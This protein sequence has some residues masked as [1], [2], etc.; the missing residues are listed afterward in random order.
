[1]PNTLEILAGR[2]N[3][4]V[5]EIEVRSTSTLYCSNHWFIVF[6]DQNGE[7][8]SAE[9]TKRLDGLYT[10]EWTQDIDLQPT[11]FIE[12]GVTYNS[13]TIQDLATCIFHLSDPQMLGFCCCR[14]WV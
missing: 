4:N 13:P 1:M 6:R 14:Q 12:S 2:T 7:N 11:G 5:R 10:A 9:F 3:F 8:F